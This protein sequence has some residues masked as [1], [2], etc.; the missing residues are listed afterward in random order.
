LPDHVHL[1]V[2]NRNTTPQRGIRIPRCGD[3]DMFTLSHLMHAIKRNFAR[4][5]PT[6]GR[7]WQ[8]RFNFRIIDNEERFYTTLQYIKYNYRKMELPQSY[9]KT[10]W[11]Y[12]DVQY[13]S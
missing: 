5:Q 1:L 6:S 13:I 4:Q 2:F 8:P 3:N 7:L 12:V 9:G 10:P 11:V